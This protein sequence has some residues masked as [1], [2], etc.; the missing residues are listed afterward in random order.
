ME[1]IFQLLDCDYVLVN[2]LPVIRLFG[3]TK[4]GES[5]CAFYENFLPYFYILSEDDEKVID[6]LKSKFQNEILKIETVEKF[7]PIG[8]NQNKSRL[9]KITLKDPSTTPVIREFLRNISFVKDI[10]EAD[11][12]FKYRF[13]NDL[14]VFGM[15]W[16]KVI[17]KS[18][19]TTTVKVNKCIKVEKIEEVNI[20]ENVNFKYISIDIEVSAEKGIP[21]SNKD[22]IIII[23]LSF[24][25]AYKGNNTLILFSKPFKFGY[26][27]LG[28]K[29]EKDMLS[30]FLEIFDEFDPDIIVGYN[31]NNFDIPYINDRLRILKLPKNLGRCSQKPIISR[32]I[33][34]N[35]F[36]N[37]VVGRIIVDPYLIIRDM[38]KRGF[39]RGLKRF[40]LGDV[41]KHILGEEKLDVSHSEI[42]KYWNGHEQEVKKL[43]DYARKDSE[44]ALKL[45][46]EKNFLDKYIGISLVSGLLLQDSLDSGESS[47]IENLLLKEFNKEGYVIPCKPT[48]NEIKKREEEREEKGLKGAFVLE[49]KIGLHNKCVVYLDF[50]SMYPSIYIGYNICPTTL[51]I[52]KVENIEVNK[53][54]ANTI[55]VSNKVKQGLIPKIVK[56]LIEERNKVKAVMEKERDVAKKRALDAKQEALKRISNAFYGYMGFIRARLYVLDIANTITSYG[57]YYIKRT[58]EIIETETKYKVIYGD[59]DSLMIETDVTDVEEAFKIGQEISQLITNKLGGILKLK[60]ENVFKSL[61]ILTKK[62]YAGWSFEK[63]ESEWEED[64]IMKGIETVRR[65]WCDLVS[66]TLEEILQIILKEQNPQKALS[67]LKNIIQKL[68]NNQIPLEKLVITKGVSKRLEEYKGVQPHVELVKKMKKRDISSAPGVGDRVGFVI[69]KGLQLISERAEDP[70]YVKQRGLKIDSKYYIEAQL[71]PPLERVFEAMKISKSEIIGMGKQLLLF[72]AFKNNEKIKKEEIL[73]DID[74][75]ICNK[76]DK[77]FRRVPLIGKCPDCSGEILFYSHETKSRYLSL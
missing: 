7:L 51:V 9:L 12:L 64:I 14:N 59:T 71:L 67:Y 46:M 20:V 40:G 39:F 42:T 13:M 44:L 17:G 37:T 61:L 54:L 1:L 3:K 19:P 76:C 22:P 5:V 68:Q 29:S 65:D 69:I 25:P 50:A 10:F 75:F 2:N 11:I 73:T 30:K 31:I 36:R 15:R 21:D 58:K 27:T 32:K 47:K 26:D 28:F 4:E 24:Y 66:Q 53:T 16:I 62:R 60:I 18:I 38:V 56:G 77:I 34:T 23:S 55:F 8:F 45:L 35:K 43:I 49:P 72:D 52:E 6:I 70:E 41:S 74:G 33:G 63:T 57:R 48:D